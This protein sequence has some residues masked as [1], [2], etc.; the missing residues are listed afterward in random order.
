MKIE[1]LT[2]EQEVLLVKH[3]E[4]YLQYGFSCEPINTELACNTIIEMYQ[5]INK[6]KPYFWICQ[7]PAQIIMV[8]TILKNITKANLGANLWDNL[9]ANLRANLG[10]NLGDNLRANLGANLGA[11]LWANLWS[12]LWANLRDNLGDNLRANLRDNLR[13]N[14]VDNL[15]SNLWANLRANLWANLWSNLWANLRDNLGDNLRAN[16]RD[17]LRDNLVDNLW[18][19]LWA[20]LRD[21]LVDNLRANLVDNLG[22]NLVDN[23]WT[24]LRDNLGDNLRDNLNT[25]YLWGNMESYWISYYTYPERYL[26]INY[27]EYSKILVLWDNL[28]KSCG[29]WYSFDKICFISDRPKEIHKKGIQLHNESGPTLSYRD[30]YA[31]WFLNGVDVGE[32]IVMTPF[33]KLDPSLILKEKNAEVRRE[34]VRKI[35][36]ERV[37]EKL[38]AQCIDRQGNYELLLLDLNDGRTRPYLKMLNPSIGIYHIE[39]VATECRTVEQALNFRKPQKMSSIPI[40]NIY[41]SDWYQQ[42]DVCVWPKNA[43]SLKSLPK[44]LT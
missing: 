12:N 37:C 11:N 40:D 16:L 42:G 43:K 2:P 41:G 22:A 14:L 21:N 5:R 10:D 31:L 6:P 32:K 18:S 25:S 3:R 7:S 39:G 24:N 17:N 29:W 9:R 20:N 33:D 19:N 38:G 36:I 27:K 8:I 1:K 15:W 4:E 28:C 26:N 30:G 44:I 34:L 23:L 35:G 13:D